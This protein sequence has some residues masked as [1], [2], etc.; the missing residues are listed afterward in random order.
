V[1]LA[2]E[3]DTPAIQALQP[4]AFRINW[5]QGRWRVVRRATNH[6]LRQAILQQPDADDRLLVALD[7]DKRFL[8]YVWWSYHRGADGRREA[9][10]DGIGVRP[11]HR[12]RGVSK[13]LGQ[14][15]L[16]WITGEG[17]AERITAAVSPAN[18]PV[19]SLLTS[20]AFVKRFEVWHRDIE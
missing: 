4:D 18:D 8:G 7:I 3:D 20:F 12:A 5:P 1:R 16:Q 19:Q 6:R 15:C 10:I 17:I 14:C 9:I 11:E 2:N 13:V